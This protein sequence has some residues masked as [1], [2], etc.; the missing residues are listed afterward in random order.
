VFRQPRRTA[1]DRLDTGGA[2]LRIA[3]SEVNV[4]IVIV[5]GGSAGWITAN[6]LRHFMRNADITVIESSRIGILGAGEGV[7]PHFVGMFLDKIGVP[8]SD[9]IKHAGTTLKIGI[10]FT[11]W[12]GDGKHYFHPF[13]D[14][15]S[16]RPDLQFVDPRNEDISFDPVCFSAILHEQDKVLFHP[17]PAFDRD[18]NANPILHFQQKGHFAV[19]FDASRV[20][21]FLREVALSR[22]V[23]LID[24]EVVSVHEADNGNIDRII[25]KGGSQVPADLVFDCSGLHRLLIGKHFDTPWVDLKKILPVDRAMPF[26]LPAPASLPPYTEAIAMKHGWMWKIPVQERFGCGYVFDS[27]F[28]SDEEAR[29]EIR[30]IYGED[31]TCERVIKFRAGY[32]EKI[33]QKNVIAIGLASGFL[34]PLEATA[35]WAV[36]L[37]LH[38]FLRV[39][40]AVDDEESRDGFNRYHRELNKRI[41]DFLYFHYLGKRQDTPFWATFRERTETPERVQKVLSRKGMR[42]TFDDPDYLAG[43]PAPF[44]AISYAYIAAGLGLFD[45]ENVRRYWTFYGLQNEADQRLGARQQELRQQAEKAVQHNDFLEYLKQA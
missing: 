4:K 19:H 25:L 12:N 38:E 34:E 2:T 23:R 42:W 31:V 11:N 6:Y 13:E 39:H 14:F 44:H 36:I 29:E 35:I 7:T 16:P 41:V 33:W 37:T 21:A 9:L 24:D 27:D 1:W 15:L 10:R 40:L 17:K 28:C 5:G 45:I 26:T 8:L 43:H 22:G 18:P 3:A 20:A 32:Y 30:S